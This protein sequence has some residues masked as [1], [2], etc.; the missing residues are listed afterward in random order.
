MTIALAKRLWGVSPELVVIGAA[1][2]LA[3][4]A[5]IYLINQSL[6]KT[7]TSAFM[8]GCVGP[9]KPQDWCLEQ[10]RK[11]GYKVDHRTP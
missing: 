11:Q 1:T 9:N 5:S 6:Q 3:C 2:L 10:A 7:Y 8:I 4:L